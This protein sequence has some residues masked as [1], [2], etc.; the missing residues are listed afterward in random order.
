MNQTNTERVQILSLRANF[1]GVNFFRLLLTMLAICLLWMCQPL[2]QAGEKIRVGLPQPGQVPFFWRSDSGGY[3][4]I[5]PD[6]LRLIAQKLKL[7]LEFIPL[8]QAR[9]L[10][11]FTVG[12]I[13]IE[14]GVTPHT[15]A[16]KALAQVSLFSHPF[17]IVNEVIIYRPEL[18]FPVFILKDL[19]G[20]QVA[21]VRGMS[22]PAY[23][24]REDFSNEWQIAQR[25]HRGWNNI[26]LM[27]EALAMHYQREN[28]LSYNI[29]LPYASNPVAF[30]I[31]R[32]KQHLLQGM[33]RS[34]EQLEKSGKLKE[35]V[36]KYLCGIQ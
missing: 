25:V 34:I 23:L 35:I 10:R 2:V 1:K 5:Y 30:R 4:G 3:Q 24:I 20:Q 19:A 13:D 11:H 16:D 8:S 33:N 29:S 22:V 6:T 21:T 17:G 18:S 27:K 32:E 31:H 14:A 26:G 36:C 28:K 7:E 9:L 12:E 15:A